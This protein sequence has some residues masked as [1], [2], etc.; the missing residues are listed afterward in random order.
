MGGA[1]KHLD[2]GGVRTLVVSRSQLDN[3]ATKYLHNSASDPANLLLD[4]HSQ[5]IQ[6]RAR[7]EW[8]RRAGS[9]RFNW[10]GGADHHLYTTSTYQK[11]VTPARVLLVDFASKLAITTAEAFGQASRS[12]A[13]DRLSA[14][15][16]LR[17]DIADYSPLTRDALRQ[18][19]PRLSASWHATDAFRVSATVAAQG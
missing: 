11:T 19:S 3:R 18:L 2:E 4:Y 17:T 14:S 1:W 12:F 13:H 7:A 15:L 5:E 8:T 6:D 9:W 16:G 10:G